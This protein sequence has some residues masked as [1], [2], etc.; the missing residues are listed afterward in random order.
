MIYPSHLKYDQSRRMP[1][2]AMIDRFRAFFKG[3][4]VSRG[5]GP[6]VLIVS[7]YSFADEHLNEVLLD[8][9]RGNPSAHCFALVYGSVKDSKRAID[10]ARNQPN[11][12]LLAWDGA[13][14]GTR[15]GPYVIPEGTDNK[16]APWLRVDK[17]DLGGGVE[18][19]AM[20]CLLGNF[21]FFGLFLERL[22]GR[23]ETE[24]SVAHA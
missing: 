23:S 13:V 8:G 2:L 9:L 15:V 19:A 20:R 1:Y 12:T 3:G 18:T 22:Y 7:G 24:T 14:V 16:D 4:D 5:F 10:Y 17:V 11:L 21:H 6:P